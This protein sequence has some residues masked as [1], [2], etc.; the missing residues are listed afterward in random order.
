MDKVTRSD[1]LAILELIEDKNFPAHRCMW[2]FITSLVTGLDREMALE[3][4]KMGI[5]FFDG[6]DRNLSLNRQDNHI[7]PEED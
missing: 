7:I 6:V 4:E 5:A 3:L 1:A 2:D